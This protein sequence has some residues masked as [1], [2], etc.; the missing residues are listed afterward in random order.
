MN[1]QCSLIKAL[2]VQEDMRPIRIIGFINNTGVKMQ[3]EC[4]LE[5]NESSNLKMFSWWEEFLDVQFRMNDAMY[6]YKDVP[7]SIMLEMIQAESKGK[8]FTQNIKGKYEYE[9]LGD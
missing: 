6:R 5:E 2:I 4:Y 3:I 1:Y 9:K 8:Y 7:I